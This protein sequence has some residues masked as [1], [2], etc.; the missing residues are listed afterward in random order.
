[1]SR[2]STIII[3]ILM[4]IALLGVSVIQFFWI[5]WSL[6]IKENNFNN[7]VYQAINFVKIRLLED[8]ETKEFYQTYLQ[9]KKGDVHLQNILKGSDGWGK[10]QLEY[11][12]RNN[13]LLIKP[14]EFIENIDI[15]KL[16]EYLM[17]EL[18]NQGINIDYEYGIFSKETQSFFI[19]NGNYVAEIGDGSQMS[20]V[21]SS[22]GLRETE[23]KIP[24]FDVHD[25]DEPGYLYLFFP[26]KTGVL[27]KEVWK[28]LAVS[29]FF[30]GLILFCF[31]YTLS[32]IFQQKKTS[33]IK[34]DFINNMTHEFKTPIAT[35]SLATDSIQSPMIMGN[36]VKMK[37]FLGIIKEEN[38]RMLRQV[39]KVLQ[40][41]QIDRKEIALKPTKININE[42]VSQSAH[43]AELKVTERGGNIDVR[44]GAKREIIEADQNHVSNIIAN[45][46]D[47]AEKY[48]PEQPTIIVETLD[49]KDGV[50][51][52]ITDNGI[53][54]PKESLK[55]IFEKFYRVHTGNIHDVKGFGLG[56]SY[57]KAIVDAHGGR[58]SVKS[59]PGKG[60]TFTLFLPFRPSKRE[61]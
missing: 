25:K 8:V 4:S 6:N 51:I 3:M 39:E 20:K 27:W 40:M 46:L 19:L 11:E 55:H 45:L 53:G 17:T 52:S 42:L 9:Q 54:I 16:D 14:D 37:K 12:L 29:I 35:I 43:H 38:R 30:T 50:K 28:I 1:M 61:A 21:Q 24:I 56:L 59:E 57:V 13:L 22:P 10:Q 32:V 44:L 60:S 7:Q 34:N 49:D 31:L 26:K 2:R 15:K 23:Y 5:K 58:V 36:E 47:N 41:A 33:E 48:C 18:S